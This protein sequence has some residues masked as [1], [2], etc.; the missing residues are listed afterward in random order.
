MDV[1]EF[2]NSQPANQRFGIELIEAADG[3]AVGTID[4]SEEWCFVSGEQHYLHG[5]VSFGLADTIGAAAVMSLYD[6]VKPAVTLDMRI[7]YLQ[8][9]ESDLEA[10]AEVN[11]YGS[12]NA[13]VDIEVVQQASEEPV[14]LARGTYASE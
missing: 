5:G 13:S 2:V 6:Q 14:V 3:R 12:R 9:A 8:V 4:H 1:I 11:R 7:D 10:I